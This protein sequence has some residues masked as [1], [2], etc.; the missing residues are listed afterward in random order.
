[1]EK[2]EERSQEGYQ[3]TLDRASENS[4]ILRGDFD[5]Y[6][7]YIYKSLGHSETSS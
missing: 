1:M 7:E 4:E 3:N 2:R 5:I 6:E